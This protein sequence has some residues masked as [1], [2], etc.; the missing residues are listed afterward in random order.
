MVK[1]GGKERGMKKANKEVEREGGGEGDERESL[2]LAHNI[3][4]R[5]RSNFQWQST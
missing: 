1:E 3:R 4:T 5:P 2:S